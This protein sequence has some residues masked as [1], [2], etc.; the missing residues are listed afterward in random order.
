MNKGSAPRTGIG[1]FL[2]AAICIVGL[3]LLLSFE[4]QR[5][6]AIDR[7]QIADLGLPVTGKLYVPWASVGWML[8]YDI[9]LNPLVSNRK[10][11]FEPSWARQAFDA[12]R[13][14]LVW[15]GAALLVLFAVLA[16]LLD[17]VRPNS[18]VHGSAGWATGRDLR[19]SSLT[20]PRYGVVLGQT[21]RGVVLVHDGEESVLALGPPGSGK[22]DGI[23]CPTLLTAWPSSAI[24]FDPAEE[25]T[26]ATA[27][28]RA[29]YTRVW[30]FDPR[31]PRTARYNPLSGI[32]A[33][34]VDSIRRVMA[35]YMLDRDLSDMTEQE[36][37]FSGSALELGL[38]GQSKSRTCG[39]LKIAHQSVGT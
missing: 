31:S 18:D 12:E 15:G 23:A 17:R 34:D 1:P 35:A 32:N 38:G 28:T 4:T 3:T 9:E 16:P 5:F 37:H 10:R 26:T 24:I 27:A 19:C 22:T 20:R 6:A 33:G 8:K 13:H 29:E 30:I 2:A 25:L 21:R 39:Q 11:H 36:R 7:Y 14:Q